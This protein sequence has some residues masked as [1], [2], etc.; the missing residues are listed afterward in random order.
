MTEKPKLEVVEGT[1]LPTPNDAL[2]IEG[3][4]LD[5]ALGD[6]LTETSWHTI[7]VDKPKAYFWVHPDPEYRRRTEVYAHKTEGQFETA[8]YI[9]GPKMRGRLQ[10]A[11]PCVLVTCIYRDGSPRL[12]PIMLPRENERDN[13]AWTSARAAA[14][15]AMFKW[16]KLVWA[17]RS[18]LT[19][20]AKPGYAPD[21][22]LKKLPAFN[23]LV[24]AAFGPHG[25]IQDTTHPIYRE[26]MGE[27]ATP[28]DDATD[29]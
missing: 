16:V 6:G 12:W 9:L 24:K 22:D 1:P 26:L 18:F 25:V 28:N 21:P 8:Y 23:E 2:D 4:W 11:R 29:L 20:D 7:P 19:R 3:L 10:E 27:P 17:G 14:R 15:T 5:P 13:P